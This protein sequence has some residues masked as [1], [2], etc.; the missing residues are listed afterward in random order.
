MELPQRNPSRLRVFLRAVGAA[1]ASMRWIKVALTMTYKFEFMNCHSIPLRN[2]QNMNES[3]DFRFNDGGAFDVRA[4]KQLSV[5]GSE[6]T[7]SESNKRA[8]ISLEFQRAVSGRERAAL[9]NA[10]L[11][12]TT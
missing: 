2:F 8:S 10:G 6:E 1:P 12:V 4:S 9:S 7:L 3:K 5:G 11:R